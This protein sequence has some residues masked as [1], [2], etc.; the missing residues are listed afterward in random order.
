MS[1]RQKAEPPHVDPP[2]YA[3]TC[4]VSLIGT[5]RIVERG[6]SLVRLD[7]GPKA[8]LEPLGGA[9]EQQTPLLQRAFKQLEEYLAGTRESFDL[10]LAPEGT[11]FQRKVWDALLQI[12]YGQTRSY[13]QIAEAVDSPRGFRAVGMANNRNPIAVFIPCHRVV[14]ADGSMVGYGGGLPIKEAL[15][16]LEGCL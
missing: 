6:Q 3:L 14:G 10:P 15:L 1:S 13:R 11:P 9:V 2:A 4:E 7:L 5:V 16:K 12:P 8:P